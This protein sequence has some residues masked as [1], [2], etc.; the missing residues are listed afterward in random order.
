MFDHLFQL[1]SPSFLQLFPSTRMAATMPIELANDPSLDILDQP[2]WSFLAAV[3]LH[4]VPHQ[5]QF[6][7]TA[8]REKVLHNVLTV[9]K[10][11]V[12]DEDTRQTKLANVNV[13]LHA[14]G[15]DSSHITM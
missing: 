14:L 12:A 2:V 1:L 9:N 7:V 5:H 15:L 3:A 8:V 4:G 13:F 11:W 6:L 10:G